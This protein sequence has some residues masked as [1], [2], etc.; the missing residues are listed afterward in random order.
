MTVGS[1]V[2]LNDNNEWNGL[3]GVVKYMHKDVAYIFCIQN[4]CYLY[5]ATE[6]NNVCTIKE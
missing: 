1:I 3:Y 6:K 4:P 2:R 5:V